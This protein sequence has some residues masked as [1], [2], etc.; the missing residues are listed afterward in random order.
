MK[1]FRN[2]LLAVVF[3]ASAV[4]ADPLAGT[5][6][7]VLQTRDGQNITI[8][9]VVFTPKDG[10]TYFDVQFDRSKFTEYFLSMVEFKCVEGPELNCHVPYPY[11]NPKIVSAEDL[12]WL[13]HSLLFFTKSRADYGAQLAKGVIYTMKLSDGGIV[14][15]PQSIDL[16]MIA[17]PPEDRSKAAFTSADRYDFQPGER[18]VQS[19]SLVD[20]R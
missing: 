3:S 19:L 5:K 7:I 1:I 6:D 11:A 4:G 2:A 18:W 8:G 12:S 16:N 15:A 9:A 14:G 17:T 13:E 10:K 20:H